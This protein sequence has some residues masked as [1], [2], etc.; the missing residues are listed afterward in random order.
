MGIIQRFFLNPPNKSFI[1]NLFWEISLKFER[2][3]V[4][5]LFYCFNIKNILVVDIYFL[6]NSTESAAH[7]SG[8]IV[9]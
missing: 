7:Y 9:V 3:S 5:E 1:G 8:K 4:S 2:I 6:L